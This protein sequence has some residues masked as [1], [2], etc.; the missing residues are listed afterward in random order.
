MLAL[1]LALSFSSIGLAKTPEEKAAAKEAKLQKKRDKEL[2]KVQ[3]K[4]NMKKVEEWAEGGD[5]QAQLI[6]S[7]A[8]RT[9]QR[10]N[11]KHRKQLEREWYEKAAAVNPELAEHFIPL[12]YYKKEAPLER[13]FGVSA[14]LAQIGEYVEV[15]IEDA[16]RW[17]QLGESEYDELSLA[18]IGT[19][20][21]T[22]RGFD[23]DYEKA[24]EYFKCA[25]DE[26]IALYHLS[27]AYFNGNGVEKDLRRGKFYADYLKLV[28]QAKIDKRR[29]K[30][31]RKKDRKTKR[32]EE[33]SE[34]N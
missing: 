33:Q 28:S 29:A 10:V 11:K 15:S 24:I 8:Y 13:L 22:G 9:K 30:M 5:V 4:D 1:V 21:Y 3:R 20:Y 18:V 27:D 17:A 25:G 23:Q 32:H 14:C 34:A 6:L 16:I 26:P 2:L 12:E 31:Q 19:A 7:Y